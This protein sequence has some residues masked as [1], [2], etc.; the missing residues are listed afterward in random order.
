MLILAGQIEPSSQ[1]T[2]TAMFNS[3]AGKGSDWQEAILIV[4]KLNEDGTWSELSKIKLQGAAGEPKIELNP[5]IID[6]GVVGVMQT[7]RSKFQV[8]NDGNAILKFEIEND[9]ESQDEIY[10]DSDVPLSPAL[11]SIPAQES[12]IFYVNFNTSISGRYNTNIKFHS[13]VGSCVLHIIGESA[14]YQLY[15]ENIPPILDFGHVDITRT[16]EVE[17]QIANDC[18]HPLEISCA[19]YS[20]EPSDQTM[21]TRITEAISVYPSRFTLQPTRDIDNRFTATLKSMVFTR[22]IFSDGLLDSSYVDQFDTANPTKYYLEI[23]EPH[24]TAKIIPMVVKYEIYNITLKNWDK[25][26]NLSEINFGE[27][28][29]VEFYI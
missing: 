4:Q 8:I 15:T 24:C 5:S 1:A 28:V 3:I 27:V 18:S 6:F 2:I 22:P 13:I 23:S 20:S 26:E 16:S 11:I 12:K 10:L 14:P 7:I 29:R 17:F 25:T 21:T 9:W 19:V